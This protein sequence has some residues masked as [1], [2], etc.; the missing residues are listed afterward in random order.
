MTLRRE[1]STTTI[2]YYHHRTTS[3]QY[4]EY[5]ASLLCT[6]C[7][8]GCLLLRRDSEYVCSGLSF[9]G[10]LFFGSSMF[11]C[12]GEGLEE[13]SLPAFQISI[14]AGPKDLGAQETVVTGARLLKLYWR[15]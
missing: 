6:E 1:V 9:F 8:E 10:V 11:T 13:L 5:S 2:N 12:G 7:F 3:L 4:T 14:L 15:S